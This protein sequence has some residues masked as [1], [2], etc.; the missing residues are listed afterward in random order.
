MA[1]NAKRIW[2][3]ARLGRYAM[4]WEVTVASWSRVRHAHR[5]AD[6][7]RRMY[8]QRRTALAIACF[9][10]ITIAVALAIYIRP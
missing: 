9:A 10:V 2:E 7:L 4:D 1:D 3:A 8:R 5:R 6:E